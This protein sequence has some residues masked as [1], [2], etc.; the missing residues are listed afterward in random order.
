MRAALYLVL[1]ILDLGFA[2]YF[3][4]NGRIVLPAILTLAGLCFVAATVGVLMKK[5][6]R[7]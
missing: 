3:Y 7:A 2:W 6:A 1:A 4:S 5:D